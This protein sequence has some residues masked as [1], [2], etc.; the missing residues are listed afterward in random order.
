M[1]R[2]HPGY[3][4]KLLAALQCPFRHVLLLDADCFPIEAPEKVFDWQGYK[5]SG[6]VFF[7]SGKPIADFSLASYGESGIEEWET[8]QFA[9]DKKRHWHSLSLAAWLGNWSANSFRMVIGDPECLSIAWRKT[10]A[11]SWSPPT[12]IERNGFAVW[13]RDGDGLLAF[14][15]RIGDKGIRERVT[16]YVHE[17]FLHQVLRKE[18]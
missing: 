17:E 5:E 1:E 15:H 12:V 3:T 16:G 9:I 18:I 4:L 2:R 8:G 14:C 11:E 13:H 6:A 7:R 10:G